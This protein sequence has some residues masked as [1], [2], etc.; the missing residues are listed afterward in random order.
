LA[1]R[2][3]AAPKDA[4]KDKYGAIRNQYK[5][6]QLGLQYGMGVQSLAAQIYHQHLDKDGNPTLS[7]QECENTARRI[8]YWHKQYFRTYW[9]WTD[10]VMAEFNL[11]GFIST[12]DGWKYYKNNYSRPTATKNFPSQAGG[13][14]MLRK[15]TI[16]AFD[17]NLP[18]MQTLHDAI[19][20]LTNKRELEQHKILLKDCLDRASEDCLGVKIKTDFSVYDSAHQYHDSRGDTIYDTINRIVPLV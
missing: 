4:T 11:K 15:A 18:V 2:A 7:L 10:R 16:N 17:A 12:D 8:Y 19:Y 3:G 6:V 5:T 1:I 14:E 20:L 13:A 9:N